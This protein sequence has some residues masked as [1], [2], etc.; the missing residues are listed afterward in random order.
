MKRSNRRRGSPKR[1]VYGMNPVRE[2]LRA[3]AHEIERLFVL[4]HRLRSRPASEL[5]AR[6]RELGIEVEEM[7]RG[8]LDALAAGFAHQGI[9]AR[10][11]EF[12]Y[13]TVDDLI[14]DATRSGRPLLVVVLDG[15]QDPQN[16]GAII[17]S[18]HALGAHGVVIPKDRSAQ[19]TPAVAKASAGATEHCPVARV[20]NLSRALD[21]LRQAGAWVVGAEATSGRSIWQLDLGGPLAIVIGGEASGIREGVLSHCDQRASIPMPGKIASLNA[22][23]A[24]GIA[25]YEVA[26]QRALG[27]GRSASDAG[28]N[29]P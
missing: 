6:A 8:A 23:V 26:R 16:L 9:V 19:L 24:T 4:D 29:S 18:A 12:R 22:S 3:H 1:L 5:L 7:G 17:R 28:R 13:A 11:R 2:A 10:L 25:L 15:I 20:V 14:A 27:A 21:V